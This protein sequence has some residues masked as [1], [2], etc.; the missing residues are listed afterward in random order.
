MVVTGGS[1]V[2]WSR[3]ARTSQDPGGVGDRAEVA[4]IHASGPMLDAEVAGLLRASLRRSHQPGSPTVLDL[5]GVTFLDSSALS[6]LVAAHRRL[7]AEGSGLI[8]VN[9]DERVLRVLRITGLIRQLNITDSCERG[10]VPTPNDCDVDAAGPPSD[11]R[12]YARL[13]YRA[14]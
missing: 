3:T 6:V 8:V 13:D 9:V 10:P 1:P 14:P 11:V 2:R 5:L 4:T 7:Q 12:R